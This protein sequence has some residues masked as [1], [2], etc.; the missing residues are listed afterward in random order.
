MTVVG[1]RRWIA[2]LAALT[3]TTALSIDMSLPAQ[4]AMAREMRV[5]PDV[6]QLTLGLFLAGFA[7]GQLLFGY[8]SDAF[9]RRRVLL[10]ALGVFAAGGVLCALSPGMT[11]LLCA[12]VVQGFGAAGG[13][14]LARAMVRDTQPLRSAA[15]M[16]ATMASALAVAPLVAPIIGGFVLS[17]LG[18]HAIF[19]VLAALGVAFLALAATSL[20]ET[21]PPER[22]APLAAGAVLRNL[23]VFFGTPGTR[24]PTALVCLAFAGQFAFIA[25]SPFVLIDRF[26]VRPSEYGLWFGA[27]ALA[28]MSGATLAR[29]LLRERAASQVVLAGATFLA[30]GGIATTVAVR[31]PGAGPV[32]L[33]APMLLYFVGVGLTVAPSTALA[34]DPLPAIAGT[35]SAVIGGLQ[36]LTGALAGWA[37]TRIGGSDPLVLGTWVG[38]TGVCAATLALVG[39]P[40]TRRGARQL[41]LRGARS[42]PGA[43]ASDRACR[44]GTSP[45][46]PPAHRRSLPGSPR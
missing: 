45:A 5:S 39:R 17:H 36:M 27:T 46:P 37:V 20:G 7:A 32:A 19:V 18:W 26:G 35:A 11:T 43:D 33:V 10:V 38:G 13:P 14:V 23:R 28:L 12:R 22:R 2:S 44:P 42:L 41:G 9:G 30:L 21:L 4:P 25:D 24:I 6:G 40:G 8:L 3:A 34:M 16:L 15:R 1:S 31:L 29:H